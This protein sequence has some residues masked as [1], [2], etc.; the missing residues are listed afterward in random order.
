[1][2]M[3]RYQIIHWF[4]RYRR[5]RCPSNERVELTLQLFDGGTVSDGG[6]PLAA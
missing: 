1:M 4:H 3:N 5:R 6:L 2:R